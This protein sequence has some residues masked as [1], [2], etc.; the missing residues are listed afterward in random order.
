MVI[1][2]SDVGVTVVLHFVVRPS[3]VSLSGIPNNA[4]C[5]LGTTKNLHNLCLF[6]D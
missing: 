2:L 4:G 5:F 6:Y 1:C 3:N